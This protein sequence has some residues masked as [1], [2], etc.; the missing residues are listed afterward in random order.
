MQPIRVLKIGGTP[1]DMGFQHGLA[2]ADEIRN[3]TNERVT[4]SMSQS[5]TGRAFS[6]HEVLSLA[7]QMIDD[8]GNYAPDL[9]EELEGISRA[10]GLSLPELVIANGFTDFVDVV[11]NHGEKVFAPAQF[12]AECTTFMA[13]PNANIAEH[14]LIGQT[15]DMHN[16][17]TPHV[18]M[19]DGKPKNAPEFLMFTLT[20][21]VGMIGMNSAG[22]SVAIN[23]LEGADG[24]PGVTWNFVVRKVLAQ[25]NIEDALK[26]ITEADLAGA[27]NYMLMDTS[28][29]GYNVEA[30]SSVKHVEAITDTTY[31]HANIC[32]SDEARSV[33]R[34]QTDEWL[35]DSQ[36]RVER[37]SELLEELRPITPD[38]LMTIT[39]D[40]TNDSYAICAL[41]EAPYYWETSGAVV[42]RPHTKEFWAVWGLPIENEYQRFTF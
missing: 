32:L 8:H 35:I 4:L 9:L 2:F 1:F 26:C 25:D 13:N 10:T 16:T 12:G 28:G 42:M 29:R 7:Q 40:R 37:A 19:L 21:C 17:A 34:E 23:N 30:M 6:R 33:E 15:W 31:A 41:P 3:L 38:D 39:R 20:G 14:G 11:Y 24:K 5:W 27:H 36:K 22:V 18:I